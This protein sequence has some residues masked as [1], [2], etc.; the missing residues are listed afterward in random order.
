V[1]DRASAPGVQHASQ[2]E[3]SSKALAELSRELDAL[4]ASLGELSTDEQS[5]LQDRWRPQVRF[6]KKRVESNRHWYY[7]WRV[8]A[9]IGALVLPPLASPTVNA[10]WARWT[11]LVVSLI[12]AICTALE[13]TFRFGNRWRLYRRMLDELRSEGWAFAYRV[14]PYASPKEATFRRFVNRTETAIR[15]FGE[16][17]I[18]DV[19]VL[20]VASQPP[21]TDQPGAG[22]DEAESLDGSSDGARS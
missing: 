7:S 9:V 6:A 15:R 18:T 16:E 8:P 1:E 13:T 19:L 20:G 3:Q 12:V 5:Y 17:Y 11:A 21:T 2:G 14:G 10:P 4:V 22:D